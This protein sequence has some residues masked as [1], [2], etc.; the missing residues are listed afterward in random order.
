MRNIILALVMLAGFSSCLKRE[1]PE[2]DNNLTLATLYNYYAAE[3]QALAYQA[4]NMA[5]MRIMEIN[6]EYPEKNNLAIVLDIDETILD[7]S[8]YQAMLIHRE[9]N[10]DSCWN[11]WCNSA[12]ARPVPGALT[13]LHLADSLGFN[14]FYL[15]NR[16]ED[17]VKEGTIENMKKYDFPQTGEDHFLLRTSTSSKQERREQI[18]K[19]YEI[20]LYCGDNL[21]DF[22][23]DSDNSDERTRE[24]K[25]PR[26]E[27]GEKFIVFPNAMYGNW[28]NALQ[29]E[30]DEVDYQTLLKEMA[31]S[32]PWCD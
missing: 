19:N 11:E 10:Y 16:K 18:E 25:A 15:S 7:N 21:G 1:T 23:E 24:V 30:K 32:D 8:P 6:D 27:F 4:Y 26:K 14:I 3:Y 17:F 31:G 2:V 28:V 13:F 22:Y 29:N 9:I 5:S 12:I 20:I